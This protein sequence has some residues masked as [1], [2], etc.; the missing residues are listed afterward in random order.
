MMFIMVKVHRE[1]EKNDTKMLICRFKLLC[2][3]TIDSHRREGLYLIWGFILV[4]P[5]L[6]IY[7]LQVL[8]P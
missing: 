8:F 2:T 1:M 4:D 5:Y 3:K 7:L 6:F